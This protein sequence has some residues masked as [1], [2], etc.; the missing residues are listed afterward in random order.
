MIATSSN[1]AFSLRALR[2]WRDERLSLVDEADGTVRAEF[3]F[4]G[5]TCSNVPFNLCFTVRLASAEHAYRLHELNCAPV[6]GVDGH[7]RMCS[8]LENAEGMLA[9]LHTEQPLLGQPL[10]TALEWRPATSPAGCVCSAPSRAHKW[11]VV[12]QTLHFA[13]AGRVADQPD[14]P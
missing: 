14:S 5:S 2:R 13:L 6:P 11:L 1:Y 12:L 10:S 4:E 3:R 9:T 7:T 8:Y